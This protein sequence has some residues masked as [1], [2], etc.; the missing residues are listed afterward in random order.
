MLALACACACA[1]ACARLAYTRVRA[2]LAYMRGRAG[3]PLTVLLLS[4]NPQHPSTTSFA[5]DIEITPELDVQ[6]EEGEVDPRQAAGLGD[7]GNDESKWVDMELV[8][9]FEQHAVGRPGAA[10]Q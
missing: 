8:L 9:P 7:R 10:S 4:P 1:C 2:L 6:A 5:P 3:P